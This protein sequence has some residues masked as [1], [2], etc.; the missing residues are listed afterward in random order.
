[1][2]ADNWGFVREFMQL[3]ENAKAME[4]EWFNLNQLSTDETKLLQQSRD[5]LFKDFCP[6]KNTFNRC[7]D[8]NCQ[9]KEECGIR[10][11]LLSTLSEHTHKEIEWLCKFWWGS[12]SYTRWKHFV[13]VRAMARGCNVIYRYSGKTV[14]AQHLR[15]AIWYLAECFEIRIK[16]WV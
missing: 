16:T 7:K 10:K 3:P 4:N 12:D 6:Y 11:W 8:R 9:C 5:T 14:M 13:P 1:M 15:G 2:A